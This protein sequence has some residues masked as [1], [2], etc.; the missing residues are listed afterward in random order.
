MEH[1][2]HIDTLEVVLYIRETA[3]VSWYKP[4]AFWNGLSRVA[5]V[6]QNHKDSLLVQSTAKAP[7][8]MRT[9]SFRDLWES[10]CGSQR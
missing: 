5:E 9:D 4:D 7:P 6:K 8:I 1:T 2:S 3:D 10:I